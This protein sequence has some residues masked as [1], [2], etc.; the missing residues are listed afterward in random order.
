MNQRPPA[1]RA[2]ALPAELCLHAPSITLERKF[3]KIQIFLKY[4]LTTVNQC[5]S[6]V[7]HYNGGDVMLTVEHWRAGF[8]ERSP[9]Y[10]QIVNQFC[11]TLVKGELQLGDRIPSIRDLAL[12]LK[13]N[14]NTIQRAYQEMER[15]ELIFSQRGMGYFV[16]KD[17]KMIETIKK[18]MVQNATRHFL[19]EMW[20]L[21]YEDNQILSELKRQMKGGELNE[22]VGN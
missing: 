8:D 5:A 3:C 13:V 4:P 6:I 17:E 19:D 21:G 15:K 7:V 2:G 10:L 9:I 22:V 14:T 20:A 18:E 11:R 16:M 1:C 12:M